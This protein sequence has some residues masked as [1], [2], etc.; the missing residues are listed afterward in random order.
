MHQGNWLGGSGCDALLALGMNSSTLEAFSSASMHL[1]CTL[2]NN[3]HE[4]A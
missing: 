4:R 2:S 3:L 1:V